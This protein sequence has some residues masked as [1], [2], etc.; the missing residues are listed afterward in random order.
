MDSQA[1]TNGD[2]VLVGDFNF[3]YEDTSNG[4]ALKLKELL[5]SLNLEQHVDEPTHEKGHTLDLVITRVT[6][7][8]VKEAQGP[9]ICSIRP[10]RECFS[11]ESSC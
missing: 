8:K 3:H 9:S 7:R 1:T 6:D 5:Y 11:Q 10:P 4:D 2:L